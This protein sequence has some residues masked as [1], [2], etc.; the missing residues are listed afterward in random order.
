M[1]VITW[2][3]VVFLYGICLVCK[4]RQKM[5]C[6]NFEIRIFRGEISRNRSWG[7]D[8]LSLNYGRLTS[9]F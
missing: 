5:Y 9:Y 1:Q 6:F 2:S 8:I 7:A 4:D 3:G